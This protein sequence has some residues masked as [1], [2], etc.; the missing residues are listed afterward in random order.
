LLHGALY[1]EDLIMIGEENNDMED[2]IHNP[3]KKQVYLFC[4]LNFLLAPRKFSMH[5]Y[6]GQH[7][8]IGHALDQFIS[9][10]HA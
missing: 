4:I 3:K 2:Q 1:Q 5:I 7:L 6:Y 9:E 10:M 8:C